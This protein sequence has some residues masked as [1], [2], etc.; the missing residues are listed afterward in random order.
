MRLMA[1]AVE[2]SRRNAL[3]ID[4][5]AGVMVSKEEIVAAIEKAKQMM[6]EAGIDSGVTS[7]DLVSWFESELPVPELSVGDMVV[8]PLLVVHELTEIEEIMK[9]GLELTREATGKD[10]EKVATARLR[11]LANELEV[12][13]HFR[14]VGH[15]R[16]RLK[17]LEER[18]YDN[19]LASDVREQY[20]RLHTTASE[21]LKQLEA[22]GH[23]PP[24]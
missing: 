18:A 2:I 10:P 16:R 4:A 12:A 15:I 14:A 9:M 23:Q 1:R 17:G 13:K 3:P 19:A 24:R 6:A 21:M 20:R 7:E 5:G 8:D 22:A 11:A